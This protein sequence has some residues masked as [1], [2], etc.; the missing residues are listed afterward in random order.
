[1]VAKTPDKPFQKTF[2]PVVGVSNVCDW[3]A[4]ETG[5]P[6]GRIKLAMS[7]GA[8][9]VRKSN[10]G[11]WRR[12]RRATSPLAAGDS[13]KLAY[14][15][16]LLSVKPDP[17]QLV[18]DYKR[19]SVWF[20][21]PG[22][23]TQ[24]NDWGD[25]CSVLRL[26]QLHFNNAREVFPVHRLDKDACGLV[27]VAHDKKTAADLSD[28]FAHRKIRKQYRVRV[29][30]HWDLGIKSVSVPLDG[31]PAVTIIESCERTTDSSLLLVTI[32][33]GRKHQIRRHLSQNG[34]PVRGDALYGVKNSQHLH[35][36]ATKLSYRC[37]VQGRES[38]HTLSEEFIAR[39]WR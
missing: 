38:S 25:H 34:H 13:L 20:K 26:A 4:E 22:V 3:L 19:Y 36:A 10:R 39:Y 5:L 31:K 23:M 30:G 21:P 8:V 6:K 17:L 9:Q 33:T 14:N 11:K 2:S 7:N 1:M 12:L 29:E 28:L 32:E 15:S 37:P 27:M 35:L 18:T 16:A 24:G